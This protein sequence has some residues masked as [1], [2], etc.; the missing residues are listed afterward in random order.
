MV[1]GENLEIILT[2]L[3]RMTFKAAVW[4]LGSAL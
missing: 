3:L 4:S 1:D 2:D